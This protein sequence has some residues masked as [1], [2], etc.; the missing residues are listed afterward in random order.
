MKQKVQI[1]LLLMVVTTLAACGGDT[2]T[3]EPADEP[4]GEEAAYPAE[5]PAEPAEEAPP[6][7]YPAPA[8]E[9]PRQKNHPQL[10]ILLRRK[11]LPR[12]RQRKPGCLAEG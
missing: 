1:V 7:D 9:P 6:S 11:K 3:T 5:E 4:S 8:E 10:S 12:R 2:P